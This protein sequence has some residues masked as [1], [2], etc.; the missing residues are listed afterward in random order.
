MFL[1]VD[2]MFPRV[3]H[4]FKYILFRTFSQ[5]LPSFSSI[6]WLDCHQQPKIQKRHAK[7]YMFKSCI[8]IEIQ[9]INSMKQHIIVFCKKEK[10]KTCFFFL[11]SSIGFKLLLIEQTITLI[12]WLKPCCMQPSCWRGG[13]YTRPEEH[14]WW[15]APS[16]PRL[17]RI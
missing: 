3:T 10:K 16:T 12:R 13:G 6:F 5:I 2:K 15:P 8:V 17:C 1:I 11:N 14:L 7:H 9:D 4:I